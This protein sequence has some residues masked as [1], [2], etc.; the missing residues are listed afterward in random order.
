M[1]GIPTLSN[2]IFKKSGNKEGRAAEGGCA[3]R[4]REGRREGGREGGRK[5]GRE[6]GRGGYIDVVLEAAE[7]EPLRLRIDDD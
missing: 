2:L 7:L 4:G 5:G 1:L 3:W 6:G